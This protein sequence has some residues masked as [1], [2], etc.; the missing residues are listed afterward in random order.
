[1]PCS[2]PHLALGDPGGE[3]ALV[4]STGWKAK[5]S[6]Q[7]FIY[8]RR[9]IE[10]SGVTATPAPPV[11]MVMSSGCFFLV[12]TPIVDTVPLPG[13]SGRCSS[14][15]VRAWASWRVI[16][17]PLGEARVRNQRRALV[18]VSVT[19]RAYLAMVQRRRLMRRS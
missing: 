8:L 18:I 14:C 17:R 7:G 2:S 19:K 11:P 13:W 12:F 15:E 6:G 9:R 10:T 5:T 1:V 4:Q 16:G 3:H